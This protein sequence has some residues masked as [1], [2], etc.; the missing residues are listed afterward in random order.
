[1]KINWKVRLKSPVFVTTFCALVLTF[2]YNLLGMFDI[3]PPVTQDNITAVIVAVVQL[4]TALGI[5]VDPT[6][7]GVNDSERAMGY[8]EPN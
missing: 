7:K 4:L 2:V 1:M 5:L 6:T 3:V 8:T